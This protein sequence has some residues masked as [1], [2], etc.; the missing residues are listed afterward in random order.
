MKTILSCL[1][2]GVGQHR[3][4]SQ[5]DGER[6]NSSIGEDGQSAFPFQ[7]P[8]LLTDAVPHMP[9]S[10]DESGS[11]IVPQPRKPNAAVWSYWMNYMKMST[12]LVNNLT[13]VRSSS[14][15]SAD[16]GAKSEGNVSVGFPRL[17]K[18]ERA[19]KVQKYLEK[20][21]KK[22]AGKKIR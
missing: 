4:N 14:S 19:L 8:N 6:H 16:S 5:S 11:I 2:F 3:A 13:A 12:A 15:E 1:Q 9:S 18:R 22:N 7:N 21:H 17:T 10:G 20:K